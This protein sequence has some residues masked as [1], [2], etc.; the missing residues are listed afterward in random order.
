M[1]RTVTLFLCVVLAAGLI[2]ASLLDDAN[3]LYTNGRLL[4]AVP[5]YKKAILGGENPTFCYFNLANA[6]Y[7]MDSIAQAI[8]YYRACLEEAPGFFRGLL[9]C[10]IAYYSLDE[11]VECIASALRAVKLEPEN[12]KA[13]LVLAAAYRKAGAYPEAITWFERMAQLFPESEEPPQ[14]LGELYWELD[15]P[16]EAIRWFEAYPRDGKNIA[17][18]LQRLADIYESQNDLDRAA[19]C[20]KKSFEKDPK[21]QWTYYRILALEEKAGS[22]L[23]AL[24]DAR[25]GV[26][27]FPGSADIALLAG[28]IAFKLE[29]YG[30]AEKYY[31]I[32]QKNGSAGAVIGLENVRNRLQSKGQ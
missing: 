31:R 22:S 9:N 30:E 29:K 11:I 3:R 15:D 32:A 24:E 1:T 16:F 10:A 21:R 4:E 18:I 8:V 14:A 28:L 26:N 17:E 19:Y 2:H 25:E 6:Y 5:L 23:V 20:L 12:K 7:R 27:Q 13:M